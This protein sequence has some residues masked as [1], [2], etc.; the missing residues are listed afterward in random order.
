MSFW[1]RLFKSEPSVKSGTFNPAMPAGHQPVKLAPQP[2]KPPVQFASKPQATPCQGIVTMLKVCSNR[3]SR[4][5]SLK[6]DPSFKQAIVEL[7]QEGGRGVQALAALIDELLA[8]RCAEIQDVLEAAQ[9]LSPQPELL[10]SI[11]RVVSAASVIPGQ[12]GRFAPVIVG[13]GKIGWDDS[14][15]LR[16]KENA[17]GVLTALRGSS[18]VRPSA[19][20]ASS[21]PAGVGVQA[22]VDQ[23]GITVFCKHC[24]QQYRLGI[25]AAVVSDDGVAADFSVVIGSYKGGAS[26]SPDLV[27]LLAPG[28]T[29]SQ[30]TLKEV[31]RLR[32]V[33][34]AG[35]SRYWQCRTCKGVFPYPW[36]R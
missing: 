5:L 33:R 20:P 36:V 32:S 19:S 6:E 27:A 8:A 23:D 3:R 22:P 15:A 21:R 24:N 29:P 10:T 28:R 26:D 35:A 30:D 25:D 14:T 17:S 13:G 31:S 9:Y 7:K 12:H 11:E 4:L 2:P 34:A 18:P 1:R 16:I